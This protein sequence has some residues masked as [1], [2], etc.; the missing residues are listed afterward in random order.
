MN[1]TKFNPDTPLIDSDYKLTEGAAWF[2]V[3]NFAIRIHSTDEGVIVDI[4]KNGDYNDTIA[5][6]YAFDHETEDDTQ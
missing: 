2:T 1:S 5:T 6:T 3:K 4:F